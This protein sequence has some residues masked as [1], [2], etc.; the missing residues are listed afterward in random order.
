MGTIA[1]E[2]LRAAFDERLSGS[3]QVSASLAVDGPTR[4]EA[5]AALRVGEALY[6][7]SFEQAAVG[8]LHTSLDGRILECNECF[9][10]IVGYTPQELAGA[11]FQAITPPEDRGKGNTAA[12]QLL[13]GAM[14]TASFEKRYLRKDGVR[15]W[16]MLTI[17]IQ[18]D[19][20]GQPL[21]LFDDGAGHQ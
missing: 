15:T 17:S 10:R 14:R 1:Q 16:V 12:V 21:L 7:A 18:Y 6:S 2:K 11:S 20:E 5:E 19:K 13:N 9:A 3:A 4:V 8:I